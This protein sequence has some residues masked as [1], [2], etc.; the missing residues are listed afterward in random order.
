MASI[1]ELTGE[2]LTLWNLMEEGTLEDEAIT[3]AFECT[4]EEL[5]I[6]LEG[7]CKFIKNL[8]SDAAGLKAEEERLA[9]R[10]KTLENTEKRMKEAMK[11]ALQ[12]S[13]ERKIPAGSFVVGL[14]ANSRPSVVLEEQYIENIPARYLIPQDPKVNTEQI[15]K[16]L[17]AGEVKDLEGVAHLDRGEHI[18]IR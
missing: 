14:K 8:R 13:G 9:A 17:Q 7:Y 3:G 4:T 6:K 18:T 11:A 2:F 5:A 12:A 16:D 15:M 10:R 1:Y